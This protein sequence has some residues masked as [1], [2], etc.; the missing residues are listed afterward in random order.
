MPADT[1][2]RGHIFG[3]WLL[4]QMDIAGGTHAQQRARGKVATIA[5]EGMTFHKPVFVGDEVSC[6]THLVRI[7]TTSIAVRVEAWVRRH[8]ALDEGQIRV[9]SAIFTYVALDENNAKRRLPG[10]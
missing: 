7:G 1:N 5:V 4:A 8:D 6:Y 9:T 3:G 10:E 2:P